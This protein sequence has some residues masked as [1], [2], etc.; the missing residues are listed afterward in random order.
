MEVLFCKKLL[1]FTEEYLRRHAFFKKK[2]KAKPATLRKKDASTR[3]SCEFY[4]IFQKNFFTVDL[5]M[6]AFELS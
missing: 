6:A 4:E 2:I 3:F 1:K 5:R